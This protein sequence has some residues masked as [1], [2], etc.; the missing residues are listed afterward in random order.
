MLPRGFEDEKWRR[1]SCKRLDGEK[2]LALDARLGV[3]GRV[4]DGFVAGGAGA[5][6]RRAGLRAK[7]AGSGQV[8]RPWAWDWRDRRDEGSRRGRRAGCAG[9]FGGGFL[10]AAVRAR[11]GR[12]LRY[13]GELIDGGKSS[14]VVSTGWRRRPAE[15]GDVGQDGASRAWLPIAV[16]TE[17]VERLGRR[18]R[19][20]KNGA[21]SRERQSIHTIG[22]AAGRRMDVLLARTEQ[23]G[24]KREAAVI[25]DL[26]IADGL[27]RKVEREPHGHGQRR[28]RRSRDKGPLDG[29]FE[30]EVAGGSG[31][32]VSSD[33]LTGI[34]R[35]S[36]A[37]LSAAIRVFCAG[38]LATWDGFGCERFRG[39]EPTSSCCEARTARGHRCDRGGRSVSAFSARF[40]AM[41][42]RPC[43]GSHLVGTGHCLTRSATDRR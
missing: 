39:A 1:A 24:A 13:D 17:V 16:V 19:R 41:R 40:S 21:V 23:L 2:A 28:S 26:R 31:R 6:G 36:P 12:A 20:R 34:S 25:V 42:S 7:S 38:F 9:W 3:A 8:G 4:R 32:S 15:Y 43:R 11:G 27:S 37:S 33:R 10:Q 29:S 30:R 18:G 14:L 5:D 22:E 35:M